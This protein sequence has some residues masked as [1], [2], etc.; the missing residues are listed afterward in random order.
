MPTVVLNLGT[1]LLSRRRAKIPPS[2]DAIRLAERKETIVHTC[3]TA[4]QSS[5]EGSTPNL[6]SI[7]LALLNPSLLLRTKRQDCVYAALLDTKP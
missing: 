4:I 6:V 7:S 3:C 1:P 2:V 5:W